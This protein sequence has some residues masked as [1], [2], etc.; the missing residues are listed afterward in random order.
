MFEYRNVK[1]HVEV[2]LDGEFMLSADTL[3]EAKREVEKL[4]VA[5]T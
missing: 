4:E 2:F 3:Q 1:G 5:I